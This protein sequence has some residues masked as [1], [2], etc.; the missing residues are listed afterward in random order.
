MKQKSYVHAGACAFLL[1]LASCHPAPSVAS[2]KSEMANSSLLSGGWTEASYEVLFSNPVCSRQKFLSYRPRNPEPLT[3]TG[4]TGDFKI[5]PERSKVPE[6]AVG[7]EGIPTLGGGLRQ[8]IPGNIFCDATDFAASSQRGRDNPY[9]DTD[10]PIN[11]I[12][13][14][15]ESTQASDELFIAS[16]SLSMKSV[17]T[18]TC[19]AAGRGVKVKVFIHEPDSSSGAIDVLSQCPGVELLQFKSKGRLAHL[20]SLMIAYNNPAHDANLRDKVRVSFQSGNISSGTWG[21]HENWNFVTQDRLH[22]FSQDHMFLRDAINAETVSNLGKLYQQ[23]DACR[24]AKGV[25]TARSQDSFMK[26]YFIPKSGGVYDDRKE[27]DGMVQEVQ[28]ASEVWIAAHHLTEPELITALALKLKSDPTFKVKMLVDSELFWANSQVPIDQGLAWQV[29]DKVYGQSGSLT[30]SC[31]WGILET[32]AKDV[33]CSLFSRG[34]FGDPLEVILAAKG[35]KDANKFSYGP[36][37]LQ[38]AGAELR[39]VENNHLGKMLFHNKFMIFKSNAEDQGAPG[40]VF[41][42]AGNLSKAGFDKN[43]ENYYLVRVPHV[44]ASFRQ[45]FTRLFEKASMEKD[46]PLTWDV[47]TVDDGYEAYAPTLAQP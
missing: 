23:L 33:R 27:L 21:H 14:W 10:S 5:S 22:W 35:T 12:Q 2:L 24:E 31:Q 30:S 38:A 34:E 25:E 47:R 1:L 44:Y 36:G 15:I 37:T 13:D 32:K 43:F 40:A 11:R 42:G 26:N 19:E 4:S 41:T 39:F 46:L 29:D 7:P 9:R 28:K 20:K 18:W 6:I 16:F 8:H 3:L 45:Q 17:A